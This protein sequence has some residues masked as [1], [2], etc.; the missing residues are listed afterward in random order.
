MILVR[1]KKILLLC[2]YILNF[3]HFWLFFLN[4][5]NPTILA[6]PITALIPNIIAV[7]LSPNKEEESSNFFFVVRLE[8]APIVPPDIGALH[9]DPTGVGGAW[10]GA[11]PVTGLSAVTA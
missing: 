9:T 1:K 11:G 2:R 4:S 6:I 5:K 8:S 3:H 7:V 10:G